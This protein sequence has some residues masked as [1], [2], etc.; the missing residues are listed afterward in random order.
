MQMDM[1]SVHFNN[2]DAAKGLD[3]GNFWGRLEDL[4]DVASVGREE[5]G[6]DHKMWAD[7]AP[8]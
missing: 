7:F 2:E 3:V 1:P 5:G 4:G 8:V 6:E